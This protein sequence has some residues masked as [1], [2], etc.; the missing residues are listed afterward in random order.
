MEA[1][2]RIGCDSALLTINGEEIASVRRGSFVYETV[3]ADIPETAVGI[4]GSRDAL[5][6]GEIIWFYFMPE[7]FRQAE[8]RDFGH[9]LD[10]RLD[11][12]LKRR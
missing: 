12:L 2:L 5:R 9:E 8:W 3:T 6:R 10:Y 4:Y 1:G 11:R 7:Q